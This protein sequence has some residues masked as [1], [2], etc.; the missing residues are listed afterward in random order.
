MAYEG[1]DYNGGQ[2]AQMDELRRQQEAE[3]LRQQQEAEARARA[4]AE[5][6][7]AAQQQ[8]PQGQTLGQLV[9]R[10]AGEQ[11]GQGPVQAGGNAYSNPAT[12]QGGQPLS[13]LMQAPRGGGYNPDGAQQQ[14][15]Q[16]APAPTPAPSAYQ[17]DPTRDYSRNPLTGAE[18]EAFKAAGGNPLVE[19]ATSYHGG[20]ALPTGTAVPGKGVSEVDVDT[21]NKGI[22]GSE[23]YQQFLDA[24]GLRGGGEWSSADRDAW[25]ATLTA[26]GIQI[27][28]GMKIDNG[29]N[30]NQVNSLNK[31]ILIGAAIVGG[32][33]AT[34][35]ALGAFGGAA[36]GAGAAGGAAGA[37]T[38][39]GAAPWALT[40]LAGTAASVGT[41]AAMAATGTGAAMGLG[42]V[43]M[44]HVIQGIAGIA[45]AGMGMRAQN[46][47]GKQAANATR[48]ASAASERTITA[49]M[50]FEREQRAQERADAERRWAAEQ[51]QNK[52]MWDASEEERLYQRKIFEED[53]AAKLAG[54]TGGG[55][56]FSYS[57]PD[58]KTLRKKAAIQSLQALLQVGTPGQG[59][60]YT[61]A[62]L[63]GPVG[64]G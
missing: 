31:K 18:F 61:P 35:G 63:A 15:A 37:G 58:E 6:Q 42:K 36:A 3:M 5:Q 20:S 28:K 62:T 49:Q 14:A 47:A 10:D 24:R 57:G 29:G 12:P 1:F 19:G 64:R 16:A 23:L 44:P 40:P 46:Q 27:P 17:H 51:E 50:E 9:N 11:P 45:T 60:P 59:N 34:A 41:G 39:A 8:Q 22:R 33:I 38:I 4:E 25:K 13:A 7:Q 48:E 32:T 30:L 43:A 56:G 26:Q 55:G 2:Q 21:F 52:R 54:N 53:R